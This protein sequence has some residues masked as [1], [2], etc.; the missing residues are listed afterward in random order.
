M[1]QGPRDVVV[2][3]ETAFGWTQAETTDVSRVRKLFYL[4]QIPWAGPRRTSSREE[5][6]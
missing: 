4:S 3:L 2:C 1:L 5:E 6:Q